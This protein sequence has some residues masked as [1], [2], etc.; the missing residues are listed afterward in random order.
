MVR[1]RLVERRRR[2]VHGRGGIDAE[3]DLFARAFDA[4]EQPHVDERLDRLVEVER[5][6]RDAGRVAQLG[7]R[8]FRRLV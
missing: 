3:S 6:V 5:L 2:F 4:F 7:L 1:G 8:V